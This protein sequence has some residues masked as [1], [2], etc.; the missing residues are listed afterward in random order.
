MNSDSAG[1]QERESLESENN[2]IKYR[3]ITV[4]F[5]NKEEIDPSMQQSTSKLDP[6]H[7]DETIQ[8]ESAGVSNLCEKPNGTQRISPEDDKIKTI[9][10]AKRQRKPKVV[11][12]DN[13]GS[14]D[15]KPKRQRTTKPKANAI[16]NQPPPNV[17][18]KFE[19]H[20]K[21][22]W[23]IDLTC[24]FSLTADS[25]VEFVES[26]TTTAT[27]STNDLNPL[28]NTETEQY[29]P[30]EQTLHSSLTTSTEDINIEVE[31]KRNARKRKST[32]V[33]ADQ[34]TKSQRTPKST[35][36]KAEN[37]P[38]RSRQAKRGAN[39]AKNKQ[40]SSKQSQSKEVTGKQGYTNCNL[41]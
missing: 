11:E 15:I 41:K 21:Y 19:M 2:K 35:D 34:R 10:S 14:V 7:I 9:R 38:K 6:C 37:T 12:T 36:A 3:F 16:R 28:S 25:Q 26:N 1:I 29:S 4:K 22:L 39:P 30:D 18:G 8:N 17:T 33:D 40:T 5:R 20:L 13:I 23:C 27:M 24:L 31:P 32:A